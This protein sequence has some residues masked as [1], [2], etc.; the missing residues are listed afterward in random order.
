MSFYNQ[1]ASDWLIGASYPAIEQVL[2]RVRVSGGT[3]L[4]AVA[5]ITKSSDAIGPI[6]HNKH[7]PGRLNKETR[8]TR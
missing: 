6:W 8:G 2:E 1:S 7:T 3:H 5:Q 4:R